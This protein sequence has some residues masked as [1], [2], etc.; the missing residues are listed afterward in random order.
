M[1]NLIPLRDALDPMPVVSL[2]DRQTLAIREGQQVSVEET[3]THEVIALADP[4]G[5]VF[6]VA[7]LVG[8]LVQP[9]CVI[10]REALDGPI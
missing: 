10:P 8:N 5:Q 1:D 2:N 6:S 3:P 4:M 7:R 9:E